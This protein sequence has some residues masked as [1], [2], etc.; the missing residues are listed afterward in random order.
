MKP[1][2]HRLRSLQTVAIS[3]LMSLPA[4][5]Q[6]EPPDFQV[7]AA[8]RT[9]VIEGAIAKLNEIY[10]FPETAAKMEKA[11][12]ARV[13]KGEYASITSAKDIPNTAGM[14]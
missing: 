12:R 10:V 14:P 3:L 8:E 1:S 13:A 9:E 6:M 5:A 11:V 7:T 2:T 4:I